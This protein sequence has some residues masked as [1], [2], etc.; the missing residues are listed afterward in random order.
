[1]S[2]TVKEIKAWLKRYQQL[3]QE[4]QDI[5]LRLTRLRLQY[6][7][8]SAIN[9]SDMPKGNNPKDLSDYYS[10]LEEYETLLISKHTEKLGV[11]V[12]IFQEVEKLE[13]HEERHVLKRRYLDNAGWREIAAEVPCSERTVFYIHGRALAHLAEVCSPLQ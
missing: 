8:P 9:Y 5:E 2:M 6:G 1:M 3:Q 12:Q 11:T 13:D 7:T 10:A 4:I